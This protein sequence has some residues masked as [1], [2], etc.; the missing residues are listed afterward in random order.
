MDEE[1]KP[2]KTL[3]EYSD[4]LSNF[5]G[6]KISHSLEIPGQ[7]IGDRKPIPERHVKISSFVND[8]QVMK[9]IRKPKVITVRGTDAKEH[10]V[11]KI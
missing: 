2:P 9:S 4:W 11:I 3:C 5:Q 6:T 7:Y 1:L 10:K 8:V